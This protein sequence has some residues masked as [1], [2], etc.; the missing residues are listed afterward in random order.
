MIVRAAQYHLAFGQSRAYQ[1]HPLRSLYVPRTD[2]PPAAH[3]WG[4]LVVGQIARSRKK[5]DSE[6]L[7]ATVV[8]VRARVQEAHATT[9]ELV[10]DPPEARLEKLNGIA[11][12]L[13]ADI[14]PPS[15]HRVIDAIAKG[16]GIPLELVGEVH[17][18]PFIGVAWEVVQ[19]PL[20]KGASSSLQRLNFVQRRVEFPEASSQ[21]PTL[22]MVQDK[23]RRLD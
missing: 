3:S 22:A 4:W 8:E 18:I 21:R 15:F 12:R 14:L 20:V 13:G 9:S 23:L 16:I 19:I 2:R 10:G 1:P 6:R 5:W 11:V 7:L 17:G